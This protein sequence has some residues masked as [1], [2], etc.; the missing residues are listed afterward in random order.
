MRR[1]KWGIV[2]WPPA[3]GKPPQA[4]FIVPLY[5]IFLLNFFFGV[6]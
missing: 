6:L 4:I 3:S 2:P 1:S 5:T